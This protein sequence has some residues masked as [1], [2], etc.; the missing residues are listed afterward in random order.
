MPNAKGVEGRRGKKS[1]EV[2]AREDTYRS[3]PSSSSAAR[4]QPSSSSSA[5][6]SFRPSCRL[7]L[8]S[9]CAELSFIHH[10]VARTHAGE[11]VGALRH[12]RERHRAKGGRDLD[13]DLD[14]DLEED[15][16]L[17]LDLELELELELESD[18]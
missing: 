15:L 17:D 11:P 12:H 13:L 10:L 1:V 3:E 8:A 18:R 9:A 7:A 6:S 5:P 2:R 4:A 16:D 14:L